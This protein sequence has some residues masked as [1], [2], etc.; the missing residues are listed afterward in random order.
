MAGA[1]STQLKTRNIYNILV[2]KREDRRPIRIITC[3]EVVWL[4]IGT[5]RCLVYIP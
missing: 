2:L 3:C 1:C 4:R 5:S